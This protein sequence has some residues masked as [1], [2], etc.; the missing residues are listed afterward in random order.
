MGAGVPPAERLTLHRNGRAPIPDLTECGRPPTLYA[1]Q[2]SRV[3]TW[4]ALSEDAVA[5]VAVVGGGFAGLS[6]AWHL[7]ETGR[8]VVLLE[9]ARIGAGASGR[10]GGQAHSGQRPDLSFL[11]HKLGLPASR[12]LWDVAEDAKALVR[13]V[14]A[15]D[16]DGCFLREGLISVAHTE[17]HATELREEAEALASRYDYNKLAI[18]NREATATAVGSSRF[19]AGVRDAGA[20]HLDPYRLALAFAARAE[21]AGARVCEATRAARIEPAHGGWR[22]G[23]D[24]GPAV[25]AT[26]VIVT[27]NGYLGRL[28]PKVAARVLPINNYIAATAPLPDATFETIIPGGEAVSDSRFV[29]RYWRPTPD[30]RICFGGGESSGTRI[31]SDIAERVRPYFAEI[32]PQLATV[33]ID[34][35]WGGTLAITPTRSPYVRCLEPGLYTACGFSGLGLTMAPMAG[36][37]VAQAISGDTERLDLLTRLPVPRF[38]G[39][40][41]LRAPLLTLALAA[42]AFRDRLG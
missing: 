32:Y 6:A 30:R 40:T 5:D 2:V 41:L 10:N 9:G 20:F 28:L 24:R 29:V 15:D 34:Y 18:L 23:T 21:K 16:P 22:V 27:A 35:A 8:S 1:A 37:V 25:H 7:A 38:P 11:E 31:L 39:G 12:R 42:F 3:P 19:F 13:E 17:R 4:S 14:A 33:P 36:K 26:S